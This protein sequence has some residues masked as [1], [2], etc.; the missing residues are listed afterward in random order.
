MLIKLT[1]GAAMH[2][3]NP[4]Y[5]NK[6]WIVSVYEAPSDQGMFKTLVYGGPTGSTW[7]IEESPAEVYKRIL[8]SE[9]VKSEQEK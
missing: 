8:K 9:L 5:I 3:G 7:E 1:N 6:D 4:I 2:K